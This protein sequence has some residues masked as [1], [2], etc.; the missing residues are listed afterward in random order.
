MTTN[1][2]GFV[3][4]TNPASSNFPK[5]N[6]KHIS[7]QTKIIYDEKPDEFVKEK[8]GMSKRS[9][10]AIGAGVLLA[11]VAGTFALLKGRGVNLAQEVNLQKFKEMGGVFRN[12]K[13]YING[14]KVSGTIVFCQEKGTKTIFE[15]GKA[16]KVFRNGILSRYYDKDGTLVRRVNY[17]TACEQDY[18]NKLSKRYGKKIRFE[19][20]EYG[21]FW[22]RNQSRQLGRVTNFEGR[23]QEVIAKG[24]TVEQRVNNF[25]NNEN[26][27]VANPETSLHKMPSYKRE[28]HSYNT[29]LQDTLVCTKPY[30]FGATEYHGVFLKDGKVIRKFNLGQIADLNINSPNFAV[31]KTPDGRAFVQ[32]HIFG[33]NKDIAS[34]HIGEYV[35]ILSKNGEFTPVQKDLI[36]ALG[37]NTKSLESH[38]FPMLECTR[39][40]KSLAGTG[41][42]EFVASEDV[43]FSGIHTMAKNTAENAPNRFLSRLQNLKNGEVLYD[44]PIGDKVLTEAIK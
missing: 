33:G 32:Y 3:S 21:R 12:G 27:V 38:R 42:S 1:S 11:A 20:T 37:S 28:F 14:R 17:N 2:F 22:S 25:L 43:L 34:R 44:C 8:E 10:V 5:I 41:T 18:L 19:E 16:N 29:S 35:A 40:I 23:K 7:P 9:K 36:K 26:Y 15:N 31:G 24:E 4:Y 13:A 39:D 30:E 6:E